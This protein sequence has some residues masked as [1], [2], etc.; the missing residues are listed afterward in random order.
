VALLALG[1]ALGFGTA[2]RG[3]TVLRVV[4]DFFVAIA[5]PRSAET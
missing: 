5:I 1:D 3:V 4:V 2:F